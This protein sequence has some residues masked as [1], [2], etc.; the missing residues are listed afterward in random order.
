[1]MTRNLERRVE[2]AVPVIEAKPKQHLLKIIKLFSKD[3]ENSY[4]MDADGVYTKEHLKHG[5]SAQQT[6][7]SRLEW[8]KY[9]QTN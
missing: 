7:L 2:I 5:I 9:I 4:H 1:M 6:W 3:S 8:R